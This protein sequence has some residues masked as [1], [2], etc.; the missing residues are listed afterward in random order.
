MAACTKNLLLLSTSTVHGTEY[1]QYASEHIKTFLSKW[2]VSNILFIPYALKDYDAYTNKARKALETFGFKVKGIHEMDNPVSAVAKAEA[3][4]IGGGNTFQLLKSLY[5]NKIVEPIQ[6]R[7]LKDGM[8]Y[9]GSSAG[10]NVAT[11]SICT[12]NDMPIV[13]PP[14]FQALSLVPFNINPHYLDPDPS[15]KHMGETR[16]E[17]IRQYHEI[18]GMPPVLGMRE[19]CILHV[20][21]NKAVLKGLCGA[22]L[23]SPAKQPK[24][25]D[26]G[27]DVSF[28]LQ[29]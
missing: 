2:N 14:T 25:L 1:L 28:L 20:E 12:T 13:Y 10:T 6:Q 5:D 9:I 11:V 4:F 18:S 8:P 27:A 24:E 23:F 19:G 15:S 17:R 26:V 22:K 21:G 3:V 7:V 29:I 16:E